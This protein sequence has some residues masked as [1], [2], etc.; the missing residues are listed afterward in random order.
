MKN[1]TKLM[2]IAV[3]I[4][5]FSTCLIAYSQS[6]GSSYDSGTAV[7]SG[8]ENLAFDGDCPKAEGDCDKKCPKGDSDK[9]CPKGD[10]DKKC[11]NKDK[12]DDDDSLCSYVQNV[13]SDGGC[14]N[15]K[16]DSD[17]KCPKGDS[18]K[19]CPKGDSDKKCP[20]GGSDKGCC[21]DKD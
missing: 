19:K 18:D 3:V 7:F 17:K 16:G 8:V 14:P 11:P 5:I 9:K 21:P 6:S 1:I 13:S 2:K 20:K 4:A 12:D 10:S 15:A